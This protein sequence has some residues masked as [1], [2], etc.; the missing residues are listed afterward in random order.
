MASKLLPVIL[1]EKLLLCLS[2][3]VFIMCPSFVVT[4][5]AQRTRY[6]SSSTLELGLCIQ[7]LGLDLAREMY[8]AI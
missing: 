5:L 1:M 3:C 7:G 8:F 6:T 4:Y 2:K